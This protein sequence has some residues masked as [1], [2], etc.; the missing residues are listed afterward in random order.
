MGEAFE[1]SVAEEVAI[2]CGFGLIHDDVGFRRR[3]GSDSGASGEDWIGQASRHS[4][5]RIPGRFVGH[6]V[7]C[8]EFGWSSAPECAECG[9][10][11]PALA[12]RGDQAGVQCPVHLLSVFDVDES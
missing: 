3:R 12:R 6:G 2:R 8:I 10:E 7:E 4:G 5:S 9:L 11:D 1:V